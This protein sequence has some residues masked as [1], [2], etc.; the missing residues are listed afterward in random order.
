MLKY[1]DIIGKKIDKI[2]K[3]LSI[4]HGQHEERSKK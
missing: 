4:D 1:Y 3:C 2:D